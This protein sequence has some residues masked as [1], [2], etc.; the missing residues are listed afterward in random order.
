MSERVSSAVLIPNDR[1]EIEWVKKIKNLG[2]CE[3]NMRKRKRSSLED[4]N[5][6]QLLLAANEKREV[7]INQI[8]SNL[9][10]GD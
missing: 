5:Q 3:R 7:F 2:R 6:L 8:R 1:T 10:N 9:V 4:R